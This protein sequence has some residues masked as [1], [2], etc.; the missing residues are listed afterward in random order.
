[1]HLDKLDQYR[2][3]LYKV[4]LQYTPLMSKHIR[5]ASSPEDRIASTLIVSEDRDHF[6]VINQG[7]SD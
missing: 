4:L 6:V 1:M 2:D 7:Y 5:E 3:I